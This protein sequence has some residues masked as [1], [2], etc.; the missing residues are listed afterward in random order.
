MASLKNIIYILICLTFFGLLHDSMCYFIVVMSLLFYNV[1]KIK[2]NPWM[3]RC[4][5][6][7]DWYC[8]YLKVFYERLVMMQTITY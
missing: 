1:V 4:V 2:K 8:T 5:Q 7:F 6:T 3:S